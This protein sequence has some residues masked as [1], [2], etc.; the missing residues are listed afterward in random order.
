M[1]PC[2]GSL[3][4]TREGVRMLAWGGQGWHRKQCP[5]R[6][7]MHLWAWG[8]GNGCM[9]TCGAAHP[10][11]HA[12]LLWCEPG[13]GARAGQPLKSR[14]DYFVLSRYND[15]VLEDSLFCPLIVQPPPP[16]PPSTPERVVFRSSPPCPSPK[17][18]RRTVATWLLHT[19][20]W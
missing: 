4:S 3:G 6:Q 11:F 8:G 14:C 5:C 2:L 10:S 18:N 15:F 1:C 12:T 13:G 9:P 17:P 19:L 7:C 20:A 16:P